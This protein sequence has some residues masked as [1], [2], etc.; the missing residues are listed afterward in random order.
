MQFDRLSLEWHTREGGGGK[1]HRDYLDFEVNGQS[2]LDILP[3]NDQI[4][5]LGWGRAEVER[6]AV[7]QLL[8]REPSELLSER[9]PLYVCPECGGLDCGTV[10]VQI[11]K[12]A[13][14]FVW[15]NFVWEVTYE[16]EAGD[17]G[18]LERYENL[19]PFKFHK[20][21]YW[22]LLNKRIGELAV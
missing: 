9:V 8:L 11:R 2:L 17:G 16:L 6:D 22:N 1:T 10:S 12:T 19:G 4:G 20:T 21:E 15:S 5:V 13:D 14:A 7:A 3:A 18:V